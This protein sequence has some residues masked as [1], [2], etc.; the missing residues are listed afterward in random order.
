M[1]YKLSDKELSSFLKKKDFISKMIGKDDIYQKSFPRI[2]LESL[3]VNPQKASPIIEKWIH[4][5]FK[6]TDNYL[7]TSVKYS[8]LTPS[9]NSLHY[10]QLKLCKDIDFFML[11]GIDV[12]DGFNLYCFK[13]NKIELK[14]EF[15]RFGN[16]DT[17]YRLR[18][19][20]N[21]ENFQRFCRLYRSR[22]SE[23]LILS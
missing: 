12:R 7:S 6:S 8:F 15:E 21:S 11:L 13:L 22:S 17:E 10:I 2:C 4:N 19:K 5:K 18:I 3:C 20:Y 23:K 14:K 16:S 9:N 1:N